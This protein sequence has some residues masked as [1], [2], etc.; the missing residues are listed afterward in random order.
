MR[1]ERS[2]A[3]KGVALLLFLGF[4]ETGSRSL[5]TAFVTIGAILD[6]PA[7]SSPF[8]QV[9]GELLIEARLIGAKGFKSIFVIHHGSP[10]GFLLMV[11]NNAVPLSN[12]KHNRVKVRVKVLD[13]K[14]F[15]K[16]DG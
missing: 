6:F 2:H 16:M 14:S 11:I 1:W 12:P 10:H 5:T 8:V 4:E 7:F 15:A 9:P 13:I 3:R